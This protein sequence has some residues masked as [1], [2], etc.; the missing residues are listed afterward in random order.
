LKHMLLAGPDLCCHAAEG[1]R[2]IVKALQVVVRHKRSVEEQPHR[3]TGVQSP[4]YADSMPQ[5]KLQPVRIRQPVFLPA[6]AQRL[7]WNLTAQHTGPVNAA[8]ELFDVIRT[9]ACRIK[10]AHQSAH[11]CSGHIVYRNVMFLQPLDGTDM[12]KAERS[13]ALKHQPDSGSIRRID[14]RLLRR[15]DLQAR[16]QSYPGKTGEKTPTDSTG[17][18]RDHLQIN[19]SATPD[20]DDD[21]KVPCAVQRCRLPAMTIASEYTC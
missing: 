21:L 12:R 6:I 15:L 5:P 10:P 7:E 9:V 20:W 14:L 13:A 11:A 4:R 18:K 19:L 2:Q 8:D 3:R 16:C 1:N 17:H